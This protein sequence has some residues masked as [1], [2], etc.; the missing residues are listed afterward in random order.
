M[1]SRKLAVMATLVAL[2]TATNYAMISLYNVKLMDLIVFVGGFCFGPFVGAS[3]GIT[4]WMVYGA[5][6]PSGFSFPIWL[7]TMLAEATY[8]VAGAFVYK[9]L[10]LKERNEFEDERGVSSVSFGILG[11]LLTFLY[12]LVTNI[13]F[14]FVSGWNILF[15]VVFGFVPFGLIHMI[16]NAF[17]FGLGCVPAIKAISNVVGG[18]GFGVFEK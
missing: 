15:S 18:E 9:S 13:V 11:M 10:N 7:A 16:S 5:V 12:D 14:G 4:S 8:G 6:N 2:S 1:N 3:I 17:F